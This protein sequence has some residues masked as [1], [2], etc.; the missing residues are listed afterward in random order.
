[1]SE[2]FSFL[3][4]IQDWHIDVMHLTPEHIQIGVD[5][6]YWLYTSREKTDNAVKI[7][8]LPVTMEIINK[9]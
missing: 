8:I 1:M 2:T 7:P 3:V 4:A 6:E 5:K 9:Y